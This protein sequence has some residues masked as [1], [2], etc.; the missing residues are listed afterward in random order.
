MGD[1]KTK[2]EAMYEI[3]EK[4]L[5]KGHQAYW[6]FPRISDGEDEG[7]AVGG[8]KVVSQRFDNYRVALLTGKS[9]DKTE[10]LQAFRAGDI[11]ILVSTVISECGI[12]CPNANVAVIEGADKFG[13]S[14]LHQIRGRVCRSTS[15]AFCFLVAE[16]AN[17]TSIARLEA[18]ERTND[19]FEIAEEDLRLRGMGEVFSTKQHGLPDLRW[20]SLVDDYDLMLEAKDLVVSGG[21]G[22]GV[23]E[24]TRIRYGD[25][26]GL[27]G[28]V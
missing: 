3:I 11:D 7:G 25:S 20:V 23:K 17:P 12:D 1:T 16:T 18:I 14:T 19:G 28:V 27:G 4:E 10:I 24:M 5:A 8:Y 21:V 22:E 2:Y 13:L 6:I 15:T 26:L 9:K